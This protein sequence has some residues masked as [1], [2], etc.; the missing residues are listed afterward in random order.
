MKRLKG[1]NTPAH[2]LMTLPNPEVFTFLN[3]E[4]KAALKF[5]GSSYSDPMVALIATHMVSPMA[6]LN[7]TGRSVEPNSEPQARG[8]GF[9]GSEIGSL[10]RKASNKIRNV[11]A[12]MIT[13]TS[14]GDTLL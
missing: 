10:Q 11:G 8:A 3:P 7:P 5:Y 1:G 6:T 2:G 13:Y 9:S 4:V 14:L 12:L